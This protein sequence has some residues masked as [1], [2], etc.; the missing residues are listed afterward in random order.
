M[1]RTRA[2]LGTDLTADDSLRTVA[3]LAREATPPSSHATP[4]SPYP[5]SGEVGP[6]CQQGNHQGA[7]H[8]VC[9]APSEMASGDN[10]HRRHSSNRISYRHFL[11]HQ[12]LSSRASPIIF[13]AFYFGYRQDGGLGQAVQVP[14]GDQPGECS[15]WTFGQRSLSCLKR[16]YSPFHWKKGWRCPGCLEWGQVFYQLEQHHPKLARSH[17]SRSTDK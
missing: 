3:F 5:L 11:L 12:F 17:P 13:I 14:A 15:T 1:T 4:H 6:M 10:V 7:S 16:C 9:P 2:E 8:S